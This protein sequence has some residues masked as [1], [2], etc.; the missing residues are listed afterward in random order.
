MDDTD[1]DHLVANIVS[2]AGDGVSADVQVRVIAY[3]AL[4]DG[5]LGERVAAGLRGA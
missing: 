4:V 1:R 2:H 5:T 3:W